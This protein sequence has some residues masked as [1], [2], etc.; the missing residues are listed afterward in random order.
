MPNIPIVKKRHIVLLV[1]ALTLSYPLKNNLSD[2]PIFL[3]DSIFTIEN[4]HYHSE[5]NTNEN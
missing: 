4:N 3:I 1:I 2:I 5:V